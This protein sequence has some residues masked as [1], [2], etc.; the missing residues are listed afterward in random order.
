M[1]EFDLLK[2]NNFYIVLIKNNFKKISNDFYKISNYKIV[3]INEFKIENNEL[4]YINVN[5]NNNKKAH[6]KIININNNLIV[7]SYQYPMQEY[8]VLKNF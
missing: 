6:I 3:T 4:Y 2:N 7:N 1:N 8:D 5:L